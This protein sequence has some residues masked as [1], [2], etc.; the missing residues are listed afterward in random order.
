MHSHSSGS[1]C[2]EQL[3]ESTC[4]EQLAQSTCAK[5][6]HGAKRLH[7]A[8]GTEQ[9]AQTNLHRAHAQSAC[10]EQLAQSACAEQLAQST[11]TE[12]L[13]AAAC[14]DHFREKSRGAVREETRMMRWSSHVS[15]HI[16]HRRVQTRSP[17]RCKRCL[18]GWRST[19]GNMLSSSS[20]AVPARP[21]AGIG[22]VE[23]QKTQGFLRFFAVPARPSAGIGVVKVQKLELFFRFLRCPRAQKLPRFLRCPRDPLRGS[24]V[25]KRS[26]CGA[27]RF[28]CSRSGL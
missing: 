20:F 21:S 18:R 17:Q 10:T 8:T 9:L 14:A 13:R 1:T 11:C 5:R 25:S 28:C 2:A 4:A 7:G 22:V 3:A 16:E 15:I 6:W 19:W 26:R 27:V 23:V 24:C 12:H